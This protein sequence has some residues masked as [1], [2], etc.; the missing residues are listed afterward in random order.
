MFY[1]KFLAFLLIEKQHKEK[2]ASVIEKAEEIY[3]DDYFNYSKLGEQSSK[4]HEID[5]E[6]MQVD[7][8]K[9][10]FT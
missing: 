9:T 8:S 3:A 7:S 5:E 2:L 1:F 10:K 6:P 4:E